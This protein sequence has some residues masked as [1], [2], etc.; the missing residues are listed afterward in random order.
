MPARS[1]GGRG[2]RTVLRPVS[3]VTPRFWSERPAADKVNLD[4]CW[5]RRESLEELDNQPAQEII[6]REIV[7][8]L[9]AALPE[10]EAVVAALDARGTPTQSA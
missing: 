8:D 3:R 5:L 6:E 10:F 2:G 9:T 4:I 7:E 1:A